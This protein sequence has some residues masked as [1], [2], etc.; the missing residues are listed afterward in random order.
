MQ[1]NKGFN[2]VLPNLIFSQKRIFHRVSQ[3][4]TSVRRKKTQI[5]PG[6]DVTTSAKGGK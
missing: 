3:W 2:F 4:Y 6:T 1:I 5:S